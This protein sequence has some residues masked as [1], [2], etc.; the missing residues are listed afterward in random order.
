MSEL[1]KA[2]VQ[3]VPSAEGIKGSLEKE[4]S[5]EASSAG[6]KAGGI[7]GT[8]MS[9]G[10]K[11]AGVAVTA[12]SA[13]VAGFAK[14]S[15]SAG[16]GFDAAMSQVAATMGKTTEEITDL[17]DFAQD[18]GATT[19]FSATEAAEALNYMALAGYDSQTSMSMLP[20]VLDL[21]AAGGIDLARA[22]DMVTDAQSA[23]GLSLDQTS[24]MVDQ[25]A[26]ASSK[27]NT[28]VEQLGDA[29]LTIGATARNVAGG[30]QEL[31]TV[32][33]VLADNGIKGSEGGTHLRNIL[34][35]LQDAAQD[36]A[37]SF[38][39]FA[40]QIYDS[41]GNMRS[42]IDI[43]GDMQ[44]GMEGMSQEAK[45]AMIS[46]VFNKTDLASV[47]A[48]LGT[49]SERFNELSLAIGDASG[50]ASQMAAT[51]L[52]NL[53]GDITLFKSALEGAQI[54]VSDGLS[55]TLRQFTQF[56][57]Q[58]LG[59]LTEAFREGGLS[60]AM[61]ALGTILADGL[62]MVISMLPE[63]INA[64][65]ELLG[66]LGQGLLDNLDVIIDAA[67]Q[68]ITMLLSGIVQA[69]PQLVEGGLQ[70]ILG[71]ASG[72]S[73]MLPEL[74]P[75]IV[76]VVLQ[77]VSTLLDNI[78]LLVDAAIELMVAL[79][80]G[81]TA[82]LPTI[83]EKIPEIVIALVG[84]FIENAP[85]LLAIGPQLIA[86]LIEGLTTAFPEAT[87]TV[88]GW[89]DSISAFFTTAWETIKNIVRVAIML[90]KE[91]LTTAFELL[92]L[93]WRLIWEN[94]G[95]TITTA[96]ENIKSVVSTAIGLVKTVIETV[97]T[98]V[99]TKVSE[100]LNSIKQTFTTVF[101]AVKSVVTTVFNAIKQAI[102][103]ALNAVRSTVSTVLNTIRNTFSTIFNGIKSFLTPII[104]WLKG[105][106]DFEWNLPHIKLPHF[107]ISG[108]FSLDPPSVPSFGIDWYSKAMD[109]PMILNGATIFGVSGNKLLG[110]GEAGSEIVAGTNTLMNM[111]RRASASEADK[112]IN[113]KLETLI[114]IISKY[115]PDCAR[116]TV[117]DGDSIIYG[118][119][120][121]LGLGVI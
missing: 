38:G 5:G 15:I 97:M 83:I 78:D 1:A 105:I 101:D 109:N 4:L 33:G 77:I 69:L 102:S 74:I 68:I 39:D 46:G 99:K 87:A 6:E 86:A 120:R 55:P 118:V 62:N 56:G 61:D 54:A 37:V 12:A 116:P 52:D 113:E 90:I 13:A 17:R 117:I 22:S 88:T 24:T 21:A 67:V 7:L 18:M 14:E 50:A 107:S 65:M 16:M 3:I 64:G 60:G 73:E 58:A 35:S 66:A 19:A 98:A 10:L 95:G 75:T 8:A 11:V 42:M 48:L 111:I 41:E 47:N 34:L 70:I 119:N 59:T 30:T 57:T 82:S 36:G 26:K 100:I 94:F 32:L 71:L 91:I 106:F 85:K 9:T 93:P 76:D 51:Q 103:T 121:Q 2:Y 27:S 96:W 31:S 63:M 49:S 44:G 84:A 79:A 108:S 23:L 25:M 110:G 104:E 43:I 92:T 112:E 40:V 28:S 115:L 80:M 114:D 89:L 72:I 53:A 45:D 81:L 29:F 20:S